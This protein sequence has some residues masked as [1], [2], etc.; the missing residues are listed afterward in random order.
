MLGNAW[1]PI[2]MLALETKDP[3]LSN[4][5]RWLNGSRDCPGAETKK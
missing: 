1:K 5:S 2:P 3:R 4:R